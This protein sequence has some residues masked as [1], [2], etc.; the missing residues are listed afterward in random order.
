MYT[1][2]YTIDNGPESNLTVPFNGQN[3]RRSRL[4]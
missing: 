4:N 1:V 3:V 2:S